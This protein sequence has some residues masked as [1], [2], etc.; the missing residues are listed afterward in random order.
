MKVR[1]EVPSI[2]VCR[3]LPVWH[4]AGAVSRAVPSARLAFGAADAA[5]G[6]AAGGGSAAYLAYCHATRNAVGSGA[7]GASTAGIGSEGET[8]T[9]KQCSPGP[10]KPFLPFVN[11]GT[12]L[13]AAVI[14]HINTK[15]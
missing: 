14:F 4:N 3:L 2:K 11:E 9:Q 6:A 13:T 7:T 12:V 15:M 10:G 8:Q 1:R 5:V